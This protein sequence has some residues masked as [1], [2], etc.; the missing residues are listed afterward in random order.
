MPIDKNFYNESS[1]KNL[2]WEPSWFGEKH[3]DD[4]L[5]RAIKKWQKQRRLSADGMCGPTTFRRIYTVREEKLESFQQK[6]VRSGSDNHII[7]NNEYYPIE[8]DKVVLPF[9]ANGLKLTKGF[10]TLFI[11][12]N[13]KDESPTYKV[14]IG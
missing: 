13:D 9:N 11:G 7:Y 5:V 10:K 2:G 3:F 6:E 14:V 4:K 12:R 8:C 1:A